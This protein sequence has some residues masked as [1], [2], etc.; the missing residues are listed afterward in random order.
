MKLRPRGLFLGRL[1]HPRKR[2]HFQRLLMMW[3]T[4]RILTMHLST[5]SRARR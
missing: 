5:E 4:S 3:S 1:A 2:C